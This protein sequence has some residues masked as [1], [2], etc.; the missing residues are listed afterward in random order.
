MML[1]LT[2]AVAEGE[3]FLGFKTNKHDVEYMAV[4]LPITAFV[5]VLGDVYLARSI[6]F[7]SVR[8]WVR[9]V[10]VPMCS[11]VFVTICV[12]V[13]PRFILHSPWLRLFSTSA[14]A[15]IAMAI[16]AWIFLFDSGE[17]D[18]IKKRFITKWHRNSL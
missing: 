13:F 15:F 5:V 1:Q 12:S 16:S 2:Q 4:S 11:V 3:D 14:L 6:S 8:Y 7:M 18:F 17:R 9:K 10:V